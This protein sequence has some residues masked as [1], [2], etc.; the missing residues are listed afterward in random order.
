MG[1]SI[2]HSL[3]L[4][5]HNI[6]LVGCAAAPFYNRDLVLM[7]SQYGPKLYYELDKVV[8]ETLQ[9]NA[10][11]CMVFIATLFVTGIGMPSN[12]YAFVGVFK[13]LSL[14][15]WIAVALKLAGVFAMMAIMLVIFFKINPRLRELFA[16][17]KSDEQPQTDSE[18]EF[19][20]LRARRKALCDICLKFAVGILVFSAFMGFAS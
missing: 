18:G 16:Q 10:P 20:T 12:Y 6:A 17:F 3:L 5:L 13:Q 9:G 8:E 2:I 19:F 14:I 15:A 11:Y 4:A 7:H 1:E